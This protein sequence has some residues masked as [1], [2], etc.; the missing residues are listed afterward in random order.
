M[1][2]FE[3]DLT[4]FDPRNRFAG[5]E[6]LPVR[7]YI[8]AIRD[9]DASQTQ[10]RPIFKDVECIQIFNTKDNI[11]DRPV[12][13]TDKER[14]PRA[15]NAWRQKGES[16]PGATGTRLEHWPQMTR[17]QVEEYRYFKIFTVEQLAELPDSTAQ[18][19]MGA[20]KLKQ[21]A[22]LYVE[23][24][25]GEAPFLKLQGEIEKRDGQI[26]E[27]NAEVRRLTK[28]IEEK[29]GVTSSA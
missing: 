4:H 18:M 1:E 17:A 28:L 21:L 2:T 20:V 26:A 22:R 5:D 16:D 14:W 13:D 7:F 9:D 10:G 8:G 19:M 27:L 25:K 6:K 23:A 24:A 12:R 11:I 15:Y 3:G 29:L